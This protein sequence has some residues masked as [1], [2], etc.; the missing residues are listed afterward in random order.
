MMLAKPKIEEKCIA[1]ANY[2]RA[3]STR[4]MLWQSIA[5]NKNEKE[6]CLASIAFRRCGRILILYI[7]IFNCAPMRSDIHWVL[8]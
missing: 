3:M 8:L 7:G 1:T 6:G 4:E 5:K 2:V